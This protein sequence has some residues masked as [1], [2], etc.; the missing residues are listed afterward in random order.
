MPAT[1]PAPVASTTVADNSAFGG[2]TAAQAAAA[3]TQLASQSTTPLLST[4]SISRA[5]TANNVATLNG[6]VANSYASNAQGPAT[7]ANPVA[8]VQPGGASDNMLKPATTTTPAPVASTTAYTPPTGTTQTTLPGGA[9]GYYNQ[10]NDT[11]TDANGNPLTYSQQAGGWIDPTTGVAPT[12]TASSGGTDNANVDPSTDPAVASAVSGLPPSLQSLYASNLSALQSQQDNA[13]SVL[14]QAQATLANDPAAQAAIASIGAK[15]DQLIQAMTAKNA[16]VLGQAKSSTAAFGGLGVMSTSFLSNQMDAATQRISALTTEKNNAILAAQAAYGKED[17]DAFNTAMSNY[18]DT[19]DKM[20]SALMD[21]NTAAEKAVSDQQ[22]QQK[23]DMDAQ[24]AQVTN[25][26]KVSTANASYIAA[27]LAASGTDPSSY[28]YTALAKQLGISDPAMLA[29]AV[30]SATQDTTK[31]N[32]DNANT[33]D[34]INTRDI[35]TADD[36][37]KTAKT[38]ATPSGTVADRL[39]T[40][41]AAGQNNF[42]AGATTSDGTPV[43]DE[44]GFATPTAWKQ[45]IAQ[46]PANGMTRQQFIDNYSQYIYTKSGSI[47]AAYGLTPA[48]VKKITTAAPDT[49]SSYDFNG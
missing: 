29:S 18:N 43:I 47:S 42:V 7:P 6:A 38:L 4:S 9:T 13:K 37:A 22:A 32:L 46:A 41:I 36:Q 45:L 10:A 1:A 33:A 3:N 24:T 34:E 19:I 8:S 35:T 28:D 23:L 2:P 17:L 15:Y 40:S 20:N 25:D 16:Q 27:Q 12:A 14:A 39:Q 30:I 48:E 5:T 31:A 49:S 11:M 26:T 21:L 44:N